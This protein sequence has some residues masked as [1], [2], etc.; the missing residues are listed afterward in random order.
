MHPA[1]S[2]L[3]CAAA[4]V[5]LLAC[6]WPLLAAAAD[7]DPRPEA[8]ELGSE[9]A[10]GELLDSK[11]LLMVVFYAPW[12]KK[13]LPTVE[14]FDLAARM[15]QHSGSEAVV[16]KVDGSDKALEGL[17]RRYDVSGYPSV[18][19]FKLGKLYK[20]DIPTPSNYGGESPGLVL[21][22]YLLGLMKQ[23]MDEVQADRAGWEV[24]NEQQLALW[25]ELETA[26]AADEHAVVP[27]LYGQLL[28]LE[29]SREEKPGT[30]QRESLQYNL[31]VA[32][33]NAG[34]RGAEEDGGA[35][36]SCLQVRC[37]F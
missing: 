20:N 9:T 2:P 23:T 18:R 16:A 8:V 6:G 26:Q 31:A 5:G 34:V 12:A 21:T 27:G 28:A 29:I 1:R 4:M 32:L 25:A 36:Q 33:T 37:L 15:L 10:F 7:A 17:A 14:A 13:S 30:S 19:L 24:D 35:V 22:N 3:L 11:M